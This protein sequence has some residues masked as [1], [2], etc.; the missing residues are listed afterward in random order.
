MR[1]EHIALQVKDPLAVVDWYAQNLGFRVVRAA[2]G[3]AQTHFL[4]D[5]A[6]AVVL[7][8]YHNPAAPQPDYCAMNPLVLHIAFAVEDIVAAQD[9]L[10][11]A[12]ATSFSPPETLAS[13]DE[14]AMLRDPFGLAIQLARRKSPLVRGPAQI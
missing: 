3:P 11:K 2:G 6:G 13:G 9:Q 4:A 10:I 12:G 14:I 1:V 5:A 7:E 8:I